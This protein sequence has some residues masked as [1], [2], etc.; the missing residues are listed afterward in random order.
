LALRLA[1]KPRYWSAPP[2][3]LEARWRAG[4]LTELLSCPT[5]AFAAAER[6]RRAAEGRVSDEE[7]SVSRTRVRTV[8][9]VRAK[10]H[11]KLTRGL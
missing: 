4:E 8:P 11:L 6:W 3:I 1:Q 10:R 5:E 7:Q 9:R 2:G